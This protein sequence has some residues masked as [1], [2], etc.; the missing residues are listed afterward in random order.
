MTTEREQYFL[1]LQ[2][3]IDSQRKSTEMCWDAISRHV[4]YTALLERIIKQLVMANGGV[5][6]VPVE[7]GDEAIQNPM[8]LV[9]GNGEIRI[10]TDEEVKVW[11]QP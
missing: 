5:L 10:A 7:F 2:E 4:G 9:I 6:K 11:R 8:P 3:A 1:I